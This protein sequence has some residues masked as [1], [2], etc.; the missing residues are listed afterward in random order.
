MHMVGVTSWTFESKTKAVPVGE[1]DFEGSTLKGTRVST[2]LAVSHPI[3]DPS[4][5]SLPRILD[6]YK[7]SGHGL[8][9]R[10]SRSA[11]I[12]AMIHQVFRPLYTR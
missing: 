3:D 5:A 6:L 8:I 2:R 10:S 9:V 12:S 1:P 4:S 11:I 7:D